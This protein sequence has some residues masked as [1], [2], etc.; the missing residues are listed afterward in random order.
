MIVKCKG[1]GRT[2]DEISEYVSIA[3][4]EKMTPEEFVREEE[5][6]F[7]EKTGLFWCTS[8]YIKAG[9]PIGKA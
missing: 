6:T 5:G 2:P 9:E 7:N 1:C 3:K 8:C 4:C